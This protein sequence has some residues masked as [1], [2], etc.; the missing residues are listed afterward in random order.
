MKCKNN[1][2]RRM[3]VLRKRVM[4]LFHLLITNNFKNKVDIKIIVR[5]QLGK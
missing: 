5:V 1:Y 3:P 2:R 4:A